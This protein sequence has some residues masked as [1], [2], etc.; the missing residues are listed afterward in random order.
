MSANPGVLLLYQSK[1]NH[2]TLA[3][4]SLA[5]TVA[6]LQSTNQERSFLKLRPRSATWPYRCSD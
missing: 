2:K 3:E 5:L 4:V 1:G 6:C